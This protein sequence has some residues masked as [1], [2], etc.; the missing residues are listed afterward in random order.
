MI[1]P[2]G[3]S[4]LH[5]GRSNDPGQKH[6]EN[7]RKTVLGFCLLFLSPMDETKTPTQ[8]PKTH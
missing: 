8:K 3:D 1:Q 6:K 2:Q 5:A 7:L 4:V